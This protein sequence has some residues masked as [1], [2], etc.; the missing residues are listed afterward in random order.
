YYLIFENNLS[1]VYSK[2]KE[3]LRFLRRTLFSKRTQPLAQTSSFIP[4]KKNVIIDKRG[5][6]KEPLS[7]Y[8]EGYWSYEKFA[9]SLPLDYKPDYGKD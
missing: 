5:I 1:I 4:V 8:Y 6:L 3:E 9:N 2:E 7:A